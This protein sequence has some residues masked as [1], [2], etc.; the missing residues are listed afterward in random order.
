[1]RVRVSTVA[2]ESNKIAYSECESAD[3][4]EAL[5]AHAPYFIVICGLSGCNKFFHIIS[6]TARFSE[7][8][9]EHKICFEFPYTLCLITSTSVLR[10]A[11]VRIDIRITVQNFS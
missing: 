9:F 6:S 8:N 3:S 10:V 7:K 4:Y 2:V 1:M 5:K 11:N